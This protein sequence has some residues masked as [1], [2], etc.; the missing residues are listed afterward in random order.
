MNKSVL[1]TS[2]VPGLGVVLVWAFLHAWILHT[3]WG[4]DWTLAGWDAGI[5]NLCWLCG[6]ILVIRIVPYLPKTGVFQA[7]IVLSAVLTGLSHW[8][9]GQAL[10]RL[11][12]DYDRYL[13]F[14]SHSTPVRWVVGFL[15]IGATGLVMIFYQRWNEVVESQAREGDTLTLVREAELQKLQTQLQPHFLFNSLNSINALIL[16]NPDQARQMVQQ[17]SD[18]LRLTLSRADQPW[19]TFDRELDYLDSYLAIE[20]VRFGHRME[21]KL[22]VTPEARTFTMPT[23]ILQ[24]LLEN[25]IKYGLYGTTGK[26]VIELKAM[27][28]ADQLE[29]EIRNP[30]DADMQ[31]PTGSGFGLTGLQRRLYLIYAR[32]DLMQ[33]STAD[34]L[35][36]VT[37]TIPRKP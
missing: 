11:L 6:S 10:I 9:S 12:P 18:F 17:L 35:F 22:E 13:I 26:I 31:P 28:K 32:N 33:R 1:T 20:K 25:A 8:I 5:F 21:V 15:L 29:I 24:P 4:W 36:V 3:Y 19:V 30:F 14:L 27:M 37:L 34:N 2:I 7:V 16:T 23:L